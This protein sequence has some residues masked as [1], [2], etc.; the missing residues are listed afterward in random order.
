[1]STTPLRTVKRPPTTL[2]PPAVLTGFD[3]VPPVPAAA[4][5]HHADAVG[6]AVIVAAERQP[7][8]AILFAEATDDR[9]EAIVKPPLSGDGT[10]ISMAIVPLVCV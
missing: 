7:A 4:S 2:A 9:F 1:M 10:D 6:Q 3:T 8:A 5:R